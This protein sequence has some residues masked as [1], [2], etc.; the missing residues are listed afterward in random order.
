MNFSEDQHQRAARALVCALIL[1]DADGWAGFA[2]VL[3]LCLTERQ[4]AGLSLA[5]LKALGP[6][7]S[8]QV[9]ATVHPEAGYP[10]PTLDNTMH[11]ARWWSSF[12]TQGELKAYGVAAFDAMPAQDKAAFLEWASQDERR[13][14]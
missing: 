1:D 2:D 14:A 12:A 8:A 11:D 3:L 9:F 4:R 6:E 13:A 5:A 10:L 7:R